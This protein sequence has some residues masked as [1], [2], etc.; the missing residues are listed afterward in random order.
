MAD[1]QAMRRMH[2]VRHALVGAFLSFGALDIL[3][4]AVTL[5]HL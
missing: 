2:A 5:A 1:Y 3:V 4:A